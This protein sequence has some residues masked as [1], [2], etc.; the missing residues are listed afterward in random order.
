MH[1][2]YHR[3]QTHI[4]DRF[5]QY[6]HIIIQ[7]FVLLYFVSHQVAAAHFARALWECACACI[8]SVHC[9]CACKQHWIVL[10]IS[11]S[12]SAVFKID[13]HA[14]RGLMSCLISLDQ[15]YIYEWLKVEKYFLLF[16]S[17]RR[18]HFRI[19]GMGRVAACR[20]DENCKEYMKFTFPWVARGRS[21][22]R[23]KTFE[24]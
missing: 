14:M 8:F 24:T 6:S 1:R 17:R 10:F 9:A 2:S 4:L 15:H 21:L 16:S 20:R 7:L 22:I 13:A 3:I 12:R 19:L 11:L 23:I 5:A 18:D